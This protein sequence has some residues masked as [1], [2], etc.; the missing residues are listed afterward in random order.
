M[1]NLSTTHDQEILEDYKINI[2]AGS[3][4]TNFISVNDIAE[5]VSKIIQNPNKFNN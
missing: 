5:V 2:P 4:K 3:C 1:Q